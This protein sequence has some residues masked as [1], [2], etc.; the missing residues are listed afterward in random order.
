MINLTTQYG[1]GEKLINNIF[2]AA[3]PILLYLAL[4]TAVLILGTSFSSFLFLRNGITEITD[5]MIQSLSIPCVGIA[6]V[7]S[8]PVFLWLYKRGKQRRVNI[9]YAVMA[10]VSPEE[11]LRI[12]D[13]HEPDPRSI[14]VRDYIWAIISGVCLAFAINIIINLIGAG[15]SGEAY[16]STTGTIF[17]LPVI[18]QILIS[19]FTVPAAEELVFR[20]CMYYSLREWLLTVPSMIIGALVFGIYH[21]NLVQGIYAFVMGLLLCLCVEKYAGIVSAI[22]CHICSNLIMLLAKNTYLLEYL[23]RENVICGIIA[24]VLLIAAGGYAVIR[25]IKLEA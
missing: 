1:N 3:L 19:G 17:D 25:I 16:N 5:D 15:A 24:S 6:S 12:R 13:A 23:T 10:N 21:W 8:I 20:G 7:I 4:C 2:R 14:P 9:K 22:I 18:L 11:A